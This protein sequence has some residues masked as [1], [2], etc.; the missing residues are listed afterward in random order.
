MI[1]RLS[2]RPL[3][4][5]V[6]AC[7]GLAAPSVA[8]AACQEPDRLYIADNRLP[9]VIDDTV[10]VFDA[11]SGKHLSLLVKPGIGGLLG[12][13]G[14]IFDQG[15]PNANLLVA[16]QNPLVAYSGTVLIYHRVSGKAL[17]QL[18]PITET[19]VFDAPWAP[20]G[21]LLMGSK[22]YVADT[23]SVPANI[24]SYIHQYNRKTGAHVASFRP[25]ADGFS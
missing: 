6:I 17:G 2:T 3:A 18:M 11:N 20:Q 14:I 25:P 19:P 5:A 1:S 23:G 4:G 9:G 7:V 15:G 13:R 8:R 24:T 16:S 12:A 21:I 22:L 10:E